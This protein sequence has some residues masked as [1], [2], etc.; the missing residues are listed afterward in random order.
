MVKNM[1]AI[2]VSEKWVLGILE[3]GVPMDTREVADEVLEVSGVEDDIT[4]Q[5]RNVETGEVIEFDKDT[6]TPMLGEILAEVYCGR[7]SIVELLNCL[8]NISGGYNIKVT[9]KMYIVDNDVII[10]IRTE[11]A[12]GF[13]QCLL[14]RCPVFF[15]NNP[16]L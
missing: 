4:F 3:N 6:E 2:N 11:D 15:H 12:Q 9:D 16:C 1:K 14:Y 5:L 10:K 8:V 7:E 13:L